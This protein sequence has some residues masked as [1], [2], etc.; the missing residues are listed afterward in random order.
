MGLDDF[1]AAVEPETPAGDTRTIDLSDRVQFGPAIPRSYH[2]R[3]KQWCLDN[4]VTLDA[5]IAALVSMLLDEKINQA[6]LLTRIEDL[7]NQRRRQTRK[8]RRS[9]T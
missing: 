5:T 7:E 2:R 9:A 8:K 4:D 3:L 6:R 1:I